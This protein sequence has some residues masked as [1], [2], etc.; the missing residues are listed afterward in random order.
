[1]RISLLGATGSIGQSTLDLI[2]QH[3]ERFELRGVTANQDVEGLLAI[4]Q[5]MRPALAAMADAGAA[6]Q[7][8]SRCRE[9]GLTETE[10]L[11]GA[12][13]LEQVAADPETDRV[14]A[15]IV[16]VAGLPSVWAAVTAGKTVLL[17]NKEALVCAG[18]L[19]V[20]QAKACGATILPIDSEH[21]AMFQC[22]GPDY[23]CFSRPVGVERLILT[24]SGGPFR[25]WPAD[26]IAKAGVSEAIAH[27]NWVMGK[28]I[29]VDSASLVNKGLEFIEAHWLFHLPADRIEV[30]VHPQS[31]IHSMVAFS[32]GSTLAQLG[33]PDM[34]TPIAHALAWPERISAGVNGLRW[35]QTSRLDFEPP[36]L[37]RFPALAM[38]QACLAQGPAATNVFNAANEQAVETFLAGRLAFGGIS[39]AIEATLHELVSRL[40]DPNSLDAV[41]EIDRQAR[42]VCADWLKKQPSP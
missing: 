38:A 5:R 35:N 12:S 24:A 25:T 3:P 15:G 30:V 29:S 20:Q 2:A 21:N 8:R 42:R 23:R 27:P 33:S 22:L 11:E 31:V 10:V 14:V 41:Y 28:K 9:L 6:Q 26:R 16:G 34:R 32:D 4:V 1:M 7:L 36:D 18:A 37:Q 13:G 17:A 19:L 40:S 39:Q